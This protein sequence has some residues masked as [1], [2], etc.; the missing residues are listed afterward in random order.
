[1]SHTWTGEIPRD[2][3]ARRPARHHLRASARRPS[4]ESPSLDAAWATFLVLASQCHA[5]AR[6]RAKSSTANLPF[7]QMSR[8]GCLLRQ[9]SEMSRGFGAGPET[10]QAADG[11]AVPRRQHLQQLP[12]PTYFPAYCDASRSAVASGL[13]L[14]SLYQRRARC[15]DGGVSVDVPGPRQVKEETRN[16]VQGI[17]IEALRLPLELKQSP[18]VNSFFSPPNFKRRW[19]SVTSQAQPA[20]FVHVQGKLVR[21]GSLRSG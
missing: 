16:E 12:Y 13:P 14:P 10:S 6:V 21:L 15:L 7:L 3:A 1:M 19:C 20:E 9:H 5:H 18:K 2:P 4:L 8:T 17:N 11:S